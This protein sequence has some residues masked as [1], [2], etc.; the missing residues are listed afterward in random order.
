MSIHRYLL[1]LPIYLL[2]LFC[3]L[4][5]SKKTD[6]LSGNEGNYSEPP[7]LKVESSVFS[8]LIL[9]SIPMGEIKWGTEVRLL[10]GQHRIQIHNIGVKHFDTTITLEP[11]T[12]LYKKTFPE[13]EDPNFFDSKKKKKK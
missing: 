13:R 6:S 12:T 7:I 11:G 3:G 8:F 9:D 4:A 5:F 10:P 1:Y 2:P